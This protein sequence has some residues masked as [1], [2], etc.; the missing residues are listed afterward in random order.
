MFSFF[1]TYLFTLIA[2]DVTGKY[3]I[4]LSEKFHEIKSSNGCI[5]SLHPSIFYDGHDMFQNAWNHHMNRL[6]KS[7]LA[8]AYASTINNNNNNHV[9][10]KSISSSPSSDCTI[11]AATTYSTSTTDTTNSTTPDIST[12]INTTSRKTI[13]NNINNVENAIP[14]STTYIVSTASYTEPH[15]TVNDSKGRSGSINN[16]KTDK[17]N[18]HHHNNGTTGNHTNDSFNNTTTSTTTTTTPS[19]SNNNK[20]PTKLYVSYEDLNKAKPEELQAF[21]PSIVINT[22]MNKPLPKFNDGGDGRV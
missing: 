13:N 1:C 15:T 7:S 16:N 9:S 19:N 3:P 5:D 21:V 6:Q 18:P 11:K 10:I 14:D 8:E 12:V 17:N 20:A 4:N 2:L 22:N